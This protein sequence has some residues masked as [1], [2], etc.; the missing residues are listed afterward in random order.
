MYVGRD[1]CSDD[2]GASRWIKMASRCRGNTRRGRRTSGRREHRSRP[3]RRQDQLLTVITN[4]QVSSPLHISTAS[5][6]NPDIHAWHQWGR[7]PANLRPMA[8]NRQVGSFA[9]GVTCTTQLTP[10]SGL[11]VTGRPDDCL[12]LP[13][14]RG[15]STRIGSQRNNS[16]RFLAE[17]HMDNRTGDLIGS[18]RCYSL[19]PSMFLEFLGRLLE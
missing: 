5:R 19:R 9:H 14:E 6:L 18:R 11:R 7:T 17:I 10:G 16:I 12:I 13:L 15:R 1:G 2:P 3:A 8:K 4:P